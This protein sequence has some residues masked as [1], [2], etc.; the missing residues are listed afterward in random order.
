MTMSRAFLRSVGV[1]FAGFTAIFFLHVA[2]ATAQADATTRL[3]GAVVDAA[4]TSAIRHARV[5][6]GGGS[7]TFRPSLAV[8]TDEGGAFTM[9]VP[10]GAML[11]ITKAGYALETVKAPAARAGSPVEF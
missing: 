5:V 11:T 1:T 4:T 2:S 7:L 6:V 10:P 3:A 8:F 9:D